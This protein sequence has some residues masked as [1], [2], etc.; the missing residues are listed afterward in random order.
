MMN[1][2]TDPDPPTEVTPFAVQVDGDS[3]EW[4]PEAEI[5]GTIQVVLGER[6]FPDRAWGDHAVVILAWWIDGFVRLAG[7]VRSAEWK[8]M[9]GPY[10]VDLAAGDGGQITVS[11]VRRETVF[12]HATVPILSVAE[13]LDAAA[14]IVLRT[15]AG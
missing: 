2:A 10:R 4:L 3:L 7:G 8:F 13:Q 15:C 12:T 9:E 6:S 11:L 1:S 5:Y 14:G